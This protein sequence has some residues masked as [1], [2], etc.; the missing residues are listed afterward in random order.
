MAAAA[1]GFR[2]ESSRAGRVARLRLHGELDAATAPVLDAGIAEAVAAGVEQV[3]IDC[4]G[5]DFI[6]SSGLS[7][8]ATNHKRLQDARRAL[9]VEAAPA[10]AR[11]LFEIAGMDRVLDVRDAP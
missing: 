5:L 11:R 10:G 2:I 8:L 7:V 4:A 3:V 9:V 6:D 1:D